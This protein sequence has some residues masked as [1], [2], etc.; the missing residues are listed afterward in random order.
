MGL[1]PATDKLD[2]V[3]NVQHFMVQDVGDHIFRHAWPVELPIDHNLIE[4]GIETAQLRA[5]HPSA[6]AEARPG[7]G[8]SKIGTIQAMEQW[9]EIVMCTDR[10]MFRPAGAVST[11]EQ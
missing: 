3:F 2:A 5:P 4:R 11:E 10:A 9:I 8:I 1:A 6:P 7:K